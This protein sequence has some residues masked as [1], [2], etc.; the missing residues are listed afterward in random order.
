MVEIKQYNGKE[1]SSKLSS[2]DESMRISGSRI[3][4]HPFIVDWLENVYFAENNSVSDSNQE[5]RKKD[6]LVP[7]DFNRK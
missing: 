3:S 2:S 6:Y 5:S 1:L 7:I 4:I